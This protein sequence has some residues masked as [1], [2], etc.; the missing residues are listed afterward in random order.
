MTMVLAITANG[1]SRAPNIE[2]VGSYFPGWMISLVVGII[3]TGISHT[4]LRQKGLV[5]EVGHPALIYPSMVTL[6]TCVIWLLFFA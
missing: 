2:I 4:I 6:F 1:C 3:L 5:H